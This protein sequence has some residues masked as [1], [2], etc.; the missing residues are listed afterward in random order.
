MLLNCGVG[1]DSWESLGL[2]GDPTSPFWR[3]ST[4]G[5]LWRE[6]CWSWGSST[7]ATWCKELTHWKRPWCWERLR[8]EE[9]GPAEDERVEWHHQLSGHVV[10]VVQWLNHVQ[11][12]VIPWTAACQ[13]SLSITNWRSLLK[14]KLIQLVMPSNHLILCCPLLLL[15]SI[16]SSI[17]VFSNESVLCISW[18]KYWRFSFSISPSNE[19]SELI[20]FRI[21]WL[22]WSAC[23]PRD[24]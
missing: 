2:Q 13:A 3:R 21:D 4:L 14:L 7:L 18:P 10:A 11:L 24:S 8:A 1:E 5:F 16:F 6:W 12:F 15:P 23:S 19:Y 17:K 22:V 20:S 9:K